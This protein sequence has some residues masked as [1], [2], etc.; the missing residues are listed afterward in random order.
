MTFSIVA[1]DVKTGQFASSVCSSSP[2]VGA[3]CAFGRAGAGAVTS[4]NVTDPRLGPKVL[5]L[6]AAGQSAS[7]AVDAITKDLKF[8]EFR[9]VTAVDKEGNTAIFSG[10]NAL[11][12]SAQ[13]QTHNVCSAGN[14]LANNGVPQA[15]VDSF[16]NAP[17]SVPLG[18]RVISA[19]QAG[20]KAGGEAGQVRSAGLYLV[21]EQSWPLAD[22]RVDWT[23]DSELGP[24]DKL[25]Q[26]WDVY[27][28]QMDD[29]VT[30]C[31]NPTSAPSYGVPGDE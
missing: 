12:I 25:Q 17:I 21:D 16:S 2:A 23:E 1:F 8:K 14:L 9:Q 11:G 5:D 3:R 22:L 10:P 30:R 13:A 6:L 20:L 31:L 26:L 29:Y 4:Q 7:Q 18:Q 27:S 19:M 28:P 15:I 24:I